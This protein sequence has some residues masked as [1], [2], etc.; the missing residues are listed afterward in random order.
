MPEPRIPPDSRTPP[1][2]APPAC[3]G[4][5]SSQRA[6]AAAAEGTVTGGVHLDSKRA[7][8]Q[9]FVNTRHTNHLYI[10]G[11]VICVGEVKP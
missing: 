4:R 11:S 9:A 3:Q 5:R 1:G 2:T 10:L 6:P 8:E 7:G